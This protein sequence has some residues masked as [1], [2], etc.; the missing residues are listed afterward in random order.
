MNTGK[1]MMC[2]TSAWILAIVGDFIQRTIGADV[3]V[4]KI[5][6]V[7][8]FVIGIYAGLYTNEMETQE[9]EA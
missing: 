2:V 6:A 4:L 5:A 1:L 3:C 7:V 8:M 9:E